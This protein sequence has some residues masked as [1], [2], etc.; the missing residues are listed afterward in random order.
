[1]PEQR[2]TKTISKTVAPKRVTMAPE[3]ADARRERVARRA[4]ELFAAR[5]YVDGHD[6]EDW[7]AA[8][9]EG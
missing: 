6:L 1:M 7:L 3:T 9:S 2:S 4:Y 8:E 5:G